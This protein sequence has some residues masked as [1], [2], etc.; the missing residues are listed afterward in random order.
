MFSNKGEKDI[1]LL[2]L[3][4]TPVRMNPDETQL[5]WRIYDD[6]FDIIKPSKKT[7]ASE[8]NSIIYEVSQNQ[9]IQENILSKPHPSTVNTKIDFE[10]EFT[11]DD[12]KYLEQFG[13][14]GQDVLNKITN[15]SLRNKIIVQHYKENIKK[16]GKTLVFAID[17][18][19]CITLNEEFRKQGIESDFVAYTE[20]NNA[21]VIENFKSSL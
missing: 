8:Y 10:A 13:D 12:Y 15:S 9:L 5:L 17:I 11:E 2:G 19:H 1:K 20:G 4:A 6:N 18:A 16:Y 14:L 7:Q 3:T 21:E